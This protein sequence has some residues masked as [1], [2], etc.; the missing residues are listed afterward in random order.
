VLARGYL[1][2]WCIGWIPTSVGMEYLSLFKYQLKENVT[3]I[4]TFITFNTL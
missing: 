1:K 4:I 3:V 2:G